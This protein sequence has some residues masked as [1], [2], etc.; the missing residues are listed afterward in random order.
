MSKGIKADDA[1]AVRTV[2]TKN[3]SE[4]IEASAEKE[5]GEASPLHAPQARAINARKLIIVRAVPIVGSFPNWWTDNRFAA[6]EAG[7]RDPRVKGRHCFQLA[8]RL[9]PD[10]PRSRFRAGVLIGEWPDLG[11]RRYKCSHNVWLVAPVAAAAMLS[12]NVRLTSP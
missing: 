10:P 5:P 3:L 7:A 9:L 8:N 11:I 6:V 1:R 2:A 12:I 4:A